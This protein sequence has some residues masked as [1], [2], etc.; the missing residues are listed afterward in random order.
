MK[1]CP[2]KPLEGGNHVDA[3][4]TVIIGQIAQSPLIDLSYGSVTRSFLFLC[5][6]PG[7]RPCGRAC[8]HAKSS[9][10]NP[11]ITMSLRQDAMNCVT[12]HGTRMLAR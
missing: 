10:R 9:R 5:G 2:E 8:Y 7:V 1:Q 6:I 4:P 12:I 11:V 3:D